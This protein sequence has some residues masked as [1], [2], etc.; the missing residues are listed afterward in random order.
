MQLYIIAYDQIV[1]VFEQNEV[2]Q[3]PVKSYI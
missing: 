1:L 2:D 3:G